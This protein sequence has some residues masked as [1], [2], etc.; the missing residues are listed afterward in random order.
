MFDLVNRDRLYYSGG[1][2]LQPLRWN[3]KLAAVARA[4]SLDMAR[5]GYFNHVSPDGRS[6]EDRL[7]AAGIVWHREGENIAIADGVVQA[8][9]AFMGEPRF[10]KNH[11]WNILNPHY[12][13]VGVGIVR[14]PNGEYYITQDFIE[15]GTGRR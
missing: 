8:E 6:V 5:R 2:R 7:G 13:D 1:A 15:R 4:H 9:S 3:R 12:T 14:G 10:Q 11:R